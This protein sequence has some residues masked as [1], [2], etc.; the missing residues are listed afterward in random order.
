M[1]T[2]ITRTI[3]GL[4]Y[5]A[6]LDGNLVTISVEGVWAT[7]GVRLDS[8][9][10]DEAPA[11]LGEEVYETLE[12][13]LTEAIAERDAISGKTRAELYADAGLA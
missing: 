5:E 3:A 4:D 7:E 8:G 1:S 2:T 6:T 13:A 11:D 12:D 10:I 9:R